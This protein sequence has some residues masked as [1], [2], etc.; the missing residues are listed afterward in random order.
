MNFQANFSVHS[1]DVSDSK[2]YMN[3]ESVHKAPNIDA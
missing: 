1:F 2:S 3:S